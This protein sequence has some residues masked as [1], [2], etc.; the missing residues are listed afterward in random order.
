MRIAMVVA[1][2]SGD[3]LGAN[4]MRAMKDQN[5]DIQVSGIC[6]PAMIHEG[7]KAHYHI[8]DISSLG[9]EGLV[10]R[11]RKILAIRKKFTALLLQEPPDVFIGIDAPDFNLSIEARLRNVGIPTIQFVAPT[12]WAWRGYRIHKLK[13]AVVHLLTIYPF[14]SRLFKQAEIPFTYVGHPL[15]EAIAK[16]DT[17]PGRAAYGLSDAAKIVALLP[18]S[19][20]NEVKR[21]AAIFVETAVK[22]IEAEPGIQFIAPFTNSQT[23]ELFEQ[24]LAKINPKIPVRIVMHDSLGVIHASD[25]VIAASGTAALEAALSGRPVVVSYRVSQLTYLMVRVLSKTKYYSMLNHF[26][27]GPV[28]PEFM[29]TQ[30]TV[31]N[32]TQEALKFL[33]DTDYRNHVLER[34][35]SIAEQL[36]CD[37]NGLAV[38]AILQVAKQ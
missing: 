11:L 18:G 17:P 13:R 32:I 19:R 25:L 21:L 23:R 6:G 12:V 2:A 4:L 15:A 14:E 27:G 20:I 29:Q 36:R 24:A 16:R 5:I 37:T 8:E 38:Q 28:I 3:N 1:E 26:S 10:Q 30:C 33:R 31:Q 7:A 22:L 35:E 34:F 9:I